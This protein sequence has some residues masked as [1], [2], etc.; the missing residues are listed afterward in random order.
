VAETSGAGFEAAGEAANSLFKSP[1]GDS[2]LSWQ[3]VSAIAAMM[4]IKTIFLAF[5]SSF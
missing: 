5:I 4:V 2:E 3:P 1:A